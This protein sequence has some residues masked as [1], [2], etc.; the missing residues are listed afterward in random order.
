MILVVDDATYG[1]RAVGKV[2][3]NPYLGTSLG[4]LIRGL[5]PRGLS[6]AVRHIC[7]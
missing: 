3:V 5:V 4:P 6:H 7:M 1:V 2:G